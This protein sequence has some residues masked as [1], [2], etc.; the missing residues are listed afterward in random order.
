[1]HRERT[2]TRQAGRSLGASRGANTYKDRHVR[3]GFVLPVRG[4]VKTDWGLE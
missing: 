2:G 4:D 3:F 1:M